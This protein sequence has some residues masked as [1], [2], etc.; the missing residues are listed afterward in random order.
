ML[1]SQWKMLLVML[2]TPL[3]L[4]PWALRYQAARGLAS[5]GVVDP[6]YDES[7]LQASFQ[8]YS[9]LFGRASLHYFQGVDAARSAYGLKGPMF[10]APAPVQIQPFNLLA[11]AGYFQTNVW[12][13][14]SQAGNVVLGNAYGNKTAAPGAM[15][16][17]QIPQITQF[18][19]A[20]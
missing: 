3:L 4:S 16:P 13:G 12:Q 10:S 7:E 5:L 19:S 11:P 1:R 6:T 14:F 18:N 15:P 8:A 17:M 2:V 9:E 20:R